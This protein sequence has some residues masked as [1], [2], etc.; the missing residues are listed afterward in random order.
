MLSS[1]SSDNQASLLEKKHGVAVV[2]RYDL[3]NSATK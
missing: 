1:V 3:L 2:L